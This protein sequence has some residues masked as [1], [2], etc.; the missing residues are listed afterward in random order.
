[1]IQRSLLIAACMFCPTI[2]G[3]ASPG[4]GGA[5][6]GTNFTC[7]TTLRSC[8]C[9]HEY[10]DCKGMEKFCVDGKIVAGWCK[11]KKVKAVEPLTPRQVP[12]V[13]IRR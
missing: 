5:P 11:M 4:G 10:A 8:Q 12:A 2:V 13:P 6:G 3:A 9:N 7:D 1:M